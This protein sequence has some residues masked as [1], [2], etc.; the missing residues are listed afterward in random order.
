LLQFTDFFDSILTH[1]AIKA[2]LAN[3]EI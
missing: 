3:W 1:P 2:V